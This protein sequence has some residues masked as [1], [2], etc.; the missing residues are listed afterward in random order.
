MSTRFDLTCIIA[1]RT[2]KKK[3]KEK[4]EKNKIKTTW[5]KKKVEKW[6]M[7]A[8]LEMNINSYP[9]FLL[10]CIFMSVDIS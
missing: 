4:K 9:S 5:K 8:W 3:R 10:L 2:K 6:K 1:K 7:A